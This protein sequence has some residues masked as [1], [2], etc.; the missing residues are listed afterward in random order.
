[1]KFELRPRLMT[2]HITR[3]MCAVLICESESESKM[4]DTLF[5]DQVIDDDGLIARRTVE[6]RLSDGY[7]EH[8][9]YVEPEWTPCDLRLPAPGRY[10]IVYRSKGGRSERFIGDYVVEEHGGRWSNVPRDTEITHWCV[11]PG[12]PA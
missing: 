1:M 2:D 12:L 5:G 8:Y 7:R 4:M 10:G 3:V 6:V 11:L 9:M